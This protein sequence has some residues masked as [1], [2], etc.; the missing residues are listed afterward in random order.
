MPNMKH[1]RTTIKYSLRIL[2]EDEFKKCDTLFAW[3]INM[4]GI[5]VRSPL[6]GG[7]L[8]ERNT[9]YGCPLLVC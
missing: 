7:E 1:E 9:H 3:E 8:Y 5:C 4:I 6:F 2:D